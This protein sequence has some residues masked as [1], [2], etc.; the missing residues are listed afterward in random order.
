MESKLK[1]AMRLI[2]SFFPLIKRKAQQ[3]GQTVNHTDVDAA[4]MGEYLLSIIF[5]TTG[6]VSEMIRFTEFNDG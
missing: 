4:V 2:F 3:S 1:K 6:P 5:K